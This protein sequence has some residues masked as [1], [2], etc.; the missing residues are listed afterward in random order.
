MRLVILLSAVLLWPA[1]AVGAPCTKVVADCTEWVALG[2]GPARSLVYRSYPLTARNDRIRRAL[3]VL[4]SAARDPHNAF[5]TAAAAA[6]LAGALGDT[7]V[8]APRFA[9]NDGRSC[10]DA[11]AADEV[12]WPC[13][14]NS[15]RSGGVARDGTL[16]SFDFADELLG[17]LAAR[18]VFPRLQAI[19]V[20]G[21]SA[22]GQFAAR[23]QMANRIHETLGVRVRY[24]V[25]NPSSYAY[26]DSSRPVNASGSIAFQP[27]SARTCDGYNRWPYGLESR[28]GYA[29][30]ATSEQLRRQ[31][32]ERPTTYLLGAQDVLPN[33]AFDASC[34]AMAQGPTRLARG[35]AF[36]TLV[37]RAYGARHALIVVP[38]CGHQE[39]CMFT[40]SLALPILFPKD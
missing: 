7:I 29:R 26:P 38:R 37:N 21:H 39:S 28:S 20:A 5:R 16:T 22:G 36:A 30:S 40:A 9:S 1:A 17:K 10:G 19:V 13:D 35:Q 18:A 32:A 14:G 34:P 27:V 6:A 2:R 15:W 11:L 4:H 24:V 23:Y 8:I 12:N 3:V 25:A 31:L 33:I